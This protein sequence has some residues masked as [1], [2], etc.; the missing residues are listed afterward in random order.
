MAHRWKILRWKKTRSYSVFLGN[1][2]SAVLYS[3]EAPRNRDPPSSACWPPSRPVSELDPDQESPEEPVDEPVD[4]PTEEQYRVEIDLVLPAD[5]PYRE[6]VVS[7]C[8][9]HLGLVASANVH[10]NLT[11][12]VDPAEAAIKHVLDSLA[13]WAR[14]TI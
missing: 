1:E 4:V 10:I 3:H 13:P 2:A 8:A 9:R 5:L 14:R 7:G 11:R 6:R 12:I